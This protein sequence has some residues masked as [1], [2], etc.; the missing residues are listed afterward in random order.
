M[1]G[2]TMIN[3]SSSCGLFFYFFP[4]VYFQ[5]KQSTYNENTNKYTTKQMQIYDTIKTEIEQRKFLRV[6][7]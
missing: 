7:S 6:N 2:L 4:S 5:S 1:I 3:W